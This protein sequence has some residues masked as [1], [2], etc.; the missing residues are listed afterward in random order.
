MSSDSSRRRVRAPST[1]CRLRSAYV[2]RVLIGRMRTELEQRLQVTQV[3]TSGWRVRAKTSRTASSSSRAQ[4]R[5]PSDERPVSTAGSGSSVPASWRPVLASVWHAS[6]GLRPAA[7]RRSAAASAPLSAHPHAAPAT[8]M[9]T[10]LLTIFPHVYGTA[11]PVVECQRPDGLSLARLV[12]GSPWSEA[13]RPVRSQRDLAR[14]CA[15]DRAT[16]AWRSRGSRPAS[17]R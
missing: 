17:A 3:V 13:A 15:V 12:A 16:M 9:T 14:Q 7:A 6:E 11:R 10:R 5:G 4:K 1:G 2:R 8:P